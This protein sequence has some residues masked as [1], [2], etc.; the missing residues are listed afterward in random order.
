MKRLRG[1]GQ[2][3]NEQD[4]RAMY[5]EAMR[6]FGNMS[7]EA[8]VERLIEIV[9]RQKTMGTF[10]EVQ[11]LGFVNTLSPHLSAK[12]REKLESVLGMIE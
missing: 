10:D 4:A 12:Q 11:L 2:N 6:K 5:D 7:E 1:Y 3:G 9:R 8:L